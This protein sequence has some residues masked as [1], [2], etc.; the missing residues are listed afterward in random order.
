VSE[1][2]KGLNNF[3]SSSSY[4]SPMPPILY[5]IDGHALAYRSYF[6]LTKGQPTGRWIT[7]SGEQT[8][9]VYG[10]T[11]V[12]LR[13]LEQENPDYLAVVFDTGK[14]FRDDIYP[15]Y[16]A[17]RE[18]MPDDLRSQIERIRK[19]IDAFNIPRLEELGFEADDVLGSV[20]K[21]AVADGLGVKIFTGDRD[22]LQLVDERVI[23][24]L[25]G[26]S[27]ADAKDYLAADVVESLG[28]RP[29]Q[30]VDYKALMGD[31]SDNIPGVAG[32]GKITAS[33]LLKEYDTLDGVY[34]H[35]D[36][37]SAGLKKKLEE[38]RESAYLSQKLAAIVTDLDI[39]LDLDKARPDNFSPQ[40]V[41]VA[42][43]ELEFRSLLNRVEAL[44]EQYGKSTPKA[45]QQ[46]QLFGDA[47]KAAG[48]AAEDSASKE[49][50]IQVHIVD[51]Q[52]SLDSLA[53][54]LASASV[55][56]FDTE[57]TSTD[58]MQAELVG[59]SLAVNEQAGYYIPVG[60]QEGQQLLVDTVIEALRA[61][62]TDPNIPKAGHNLKY[63]FV[64]LARN[65]LQV[66]PLSFDS[67]LAEWLINPDSRNL[68]LKNLSWVRL[69]HQMKEIVDLI[70]KGKKQISM[71]E[72]P[73]PDVA[74][75][76]AD[77][78]VVVLRLMP[79]L[80][81][82]LEAANAMSLFE[83]IEMPL[84][85]VMAEMEMAGI[86]LDIEFLKRMSIELETRLVEIEN[87]VY[88]AVGE[89]FNLNSP[90]QLS[91]ALFDK[92]GIAPPDG[93]R[94][95]ASGYYSTAAG[96]LENLRKKNPVVE[97]VL[98]YRELAKLKSTYVDALPQQVNPQTGRVHT[99]YNQSGSRTGRIASSDPNLQNIPIRTELGR[100][101]R[102][103]FVT[104]PG[105]QLLAV[106]YS[107]VELRIA[108]HMAQDEAM[109]AAFNS[110]Q[111]I[112]ATTASAVYDVSLDAVNNTQRRHAKAINF[113]LIYG[114][115]PFGL[116]RTT[117][118]TLAEAEDFVSAY[119]RKFPG[120]KQYLDGIRASAADQGYV[121]TLLGRRRYF[122]GLMNPQNVQVRNREEREA[123]N[124]PIQGTAAD[125]MKIA[126]LQMTDAL[127]DAGLSA[128]ML[129]QVHDELVLECPIDEI[130]ATAALVSKVME[131]AFSLDIPLHTDAR[132]GD[133]WGILEPLN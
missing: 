45:G 43:R 28:V 56:A 79:Q 51:S 93:S 100:R 27:L 111:D 30:V 64:M 113:G 32:V 40:A 12:L 19:L 9:G 124:A 48:A 109:L 11:S 125:I 68:G 88:Q 99:S 20:A 101:V 50:H 75:Y 14:T 102:E 97:L 108:A 98:E 87:Q 105:H 3:I 31:S 63:D 133:N 123:I 127:K 90:K 71:A 107:Q 65:G 94:K 26:R 104:A 21:K 117:D 29:D 55:I 69:G 52:E 8:A 73:I 74:L 77:D 15:D 78:A 112:H 67:M 121:E 54:A 47:H 18:K 130:N 92:M 58:Q 66:S 35:L 60:H 34:E 126:M 17:T 86:G 84:I 118:L 37:L 49:A 36:E 33:K 25:P 16:K 62:L 38:G 1:P 39:D 114:M 85:N 89:P 116:T 81:E 70:G 2:A 115:S 24:N 120:V 23:V 6:A 7:S 110:G 103:A 13:I 128:K 96:V 4:N 46:L 132:C 83:E 131:D 61:P 41:H 59:I 129:L 76:A 122:P 57:T 91:E 72:V 10:F 80:K 95:T 119:F 22:L 44:E 5:L 42:F 53:E 82:E 106:D